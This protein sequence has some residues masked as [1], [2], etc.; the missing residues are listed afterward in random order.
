MCIRDRGNGIYSAGYYLYNFFLVMSSAGLP[1]A[2]SKMVAEKIALGQYT[3]A[4]K[5]FKVSM[6]VAGVLGFI[7][8]VLMLVFAEDFCSWVKSERSYYCIITLAPTVF[9]VSILSVY[10][11]YFQGRG[12]TVPT[13]VSYTHLDVYKRQELNPKHWTVYQSSN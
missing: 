2:I 11:G 1:V 13:A 10:R 3:N 4:R 5:I 9:V 7:C 8:M 6:A 12:T